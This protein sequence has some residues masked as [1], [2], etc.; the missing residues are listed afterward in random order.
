MAEMAIANITVR[1]IKSILWWFAYNNAL[2]TQRFRQRVGFSI[3]RGHSIGLKFSDAPSL[4]P[5]GHRAVIVLV[6]V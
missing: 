5:E 1:D 6:R 2:A 4:I 3:S